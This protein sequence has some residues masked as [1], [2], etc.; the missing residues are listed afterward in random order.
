[1]A[2]R[3]IEE[4]PILTSLVW[5]R[6]CS[7]PNEPE[8]QTIYSRRRT[9]WTDSSE[10]Q[11]WIKVKRPGIRRAENT[12]TSSGCVCRTWKTSCQVEY[13]Y[14]IKL[15]TFVFKGSRSNCESSVYTWE[16][17]S[18]NQLDVAAFSWILDCWVF[19]STPGQCIT[20]VRYFSFWARIT[21]TMHTI[22]TSHYYL[23]SDKFEQTALYTKV[24]YLWTLRP[25]RQRNATNESASWASFKLLSRT[26]KITQWCAIKVNHRLLNLIPY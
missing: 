24:S 20:R 11:T 9:D 7:D 22:P 21:L 13:A 26:S 18:D 12:W 5:L 14:Y 16:L 19:G 3:P 10:S 1:M 15:S 8:A 25:L 4:M 17:Q 2:S 6:N 23:L